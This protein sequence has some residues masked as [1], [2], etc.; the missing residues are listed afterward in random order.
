MVATRASVT[1]AYV[2]AS[3]F[4]Y[5]SWRGGFYRP[6]A[7]PADFLSL[8]AAELPSVEL[9]NPFY[10]LP[11][12]GQF[13]AWAART[14]PGFRFAVK[15]SRQITHFGRFDLIPTFCERV[16]I[17]GGQLG[18]IRL[19]FPENRQRDDGMLQLVLDSLDPELEYAFDF[20]H[21]SWDEAP[22]PLRVNELDADAPFR[23]LRFREPPYDDDALRELADRIRPLL[24]DRIRVYAYFKHEDEPT[25]PLYARRLLELLG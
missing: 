2:G 22:V 23:Y 6:D 24:A 13:E 12:E 9:N 25:A 19:Q 7:K 5:P 18:P 8:Y 15:M 16:R 4:S 3:G 10:R 1:G 17:L 14:P 11:S 21:E 20:R